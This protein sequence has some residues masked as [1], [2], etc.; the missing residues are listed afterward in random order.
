MYLRKGRARLPLLSR[1][2]A[3]RPSPLLL[4]SPYPHTPRPRPR[5]RRHRRG[6]HFPL[7]GGR[8]LC[9]SSV[10]QWSA[11]G[12]RIDARQQPHGL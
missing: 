9:A 6:G 10:G 11:G 12:L 5:L 2:P 7:V 8:I 3:V 1:T 4:R